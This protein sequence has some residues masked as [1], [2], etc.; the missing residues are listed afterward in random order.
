MTKLSLLVLM[1]F[2]N[3]VSSN[4]IYKCTLPTGDLVFTNLIK[5]NQVKFENDIYNIYSNSKNGFLAKGESG[6]LSCV[7]LKNSNPNKKNNILEKTNKK[8][9]P[10]PQN[11]YKVFKGFENVFSTKKGSFEKQADYVNRMQGKLNDFTSNN[12]I[13]TTIVVDVNPSYYNA[14]SESWTI[15]LFLRMSDEVFGDNFEHIQS[16]DKEFYAKKLSYF[17]SNKSIGFS[18]IYSESP[19]IKKSAIGN[20]MSSQNYFYL[21]KVDEKFEKLGVFE[22]NGK[23]YLKVSM[24]IKDAKLMSGNS[25]ITINLRPEFPYAAF[26]SEQVDPTGFARLYNFLT[27][28]HE[29]T[30]I[31]LLDINT[32][33]LICGIS[34]IILEGFDS[35][36]S[37]VIYSDDASDKISSSNQEELLIGKWREDFVEKNKDADSETVLNIQ[38]ITNYLHG[39]KSNFDGELSLT[40]KSI[41][42]ADDI[43]IISYKIDSI[44]AW[45]IINGNLSEET[46]QSNGKLKSLS[47]DWKDVDINSLN[48]DDS[49]KYQSMINKLL[50]K[51]NKTFSKIVS[52]TPI[53]LEIKSESGINIRS[54]K[55]S[56]K[57]Q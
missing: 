39:G 32:R 41:N 16:I 52:L 2:C 38:G 20:I 31:V 17:F 57:P 42:D 13:N 4:N 8:T 28:K 50:K 40:I 55:I 29:T 12:E 30:D 54:Y 51:N 37:K 14:E 56:S 11:G 10:L 43:F 15:P 26:N 25:K 49:Q 46:F 27:G 22:I 44:G 6:K 3:E 24:P 18:K 33:Y 35:Q 9:E 23:F 47:I 48:K 5:D 7:A 1:L 45:A 19:V 21:I 53:Q 34:K 36:K